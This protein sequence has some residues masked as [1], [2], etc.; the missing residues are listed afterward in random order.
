MHYHKTQNTQGKRQ[1]Q[2]CKEENTFSGCSINHAQAYSFFPEISKIY[3]PNVRN[4]VAS[5]A[6]VPGISTSLKKAMK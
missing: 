3:L 5:A 4:V 2:H 6:G 1:I